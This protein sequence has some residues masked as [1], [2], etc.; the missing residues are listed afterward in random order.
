[1]ID[2][3]PI[4]AITAEQAQTNFVKKT[5]H[6]FAVQEKFL[7]K[8]LRTYQNTELGRKYGL[9]DIKNIEQFQKQVPVLPYS[10]YEPYVQRVA[11]GE[12]NILTSDKVVYL[13]RTSGSTGKQK[14]IPVTQRFQNIM[15]WANLISIGFLSQGLRGQGK[16][17]GKLI[18]TYAA[19]TPELTSGGIEYG[20]AGTGVLRM[21]SFLYK[22]L[23][24]HPFSTLK[25]K[26]TLSRSYVCLLFALLHPPMGFGSNFPMVILQ[27]CNLLEQYA[28]DLI[29]DLE[30][31]TIAPWLQLEPEIRTSLEAQLSP[32]PWRAHQLRE[33]LNSVGKLTPI[34]AWPNLAFYATS[35]GGTSD[36]YL[37][38]FP[39]YFGDTPGFG[40]IFSTAEGTFSIYPDLNTDGSILAIDTGFFEFI[41]S[42]QWEE[43][44]P[45]TVLAQEVKPGEYYRILVTNHSGFYRYD[46][47][48]IFEVV[49]FY[50]QAPLLV[51]RHRRGGLLSSTTEKT[52]EYHATKVMQILQQKFAVLLEDFCI[53]LSD[54]EFPARYLVNI[55]LAGDYHLKDEDAYA[56]IESFDSILKK[57]HTNYDIQRKI[58]VPPPS[59]R[60]M[61]TGSFNIIRQRQIEKGIPVYQLKFPHISEDRNFMAG[62]EFEEEVQ[63]K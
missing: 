20:S 61:K 2:L 9:K 59:L 23:F 51:F 25:S 37:E 35:R 11:A 30:T 54:N 15:G 22:Q 21:G 43:E 4:L 52:T 5:R 40:V 1:M 3:L 44:H 10:A 14:L 7:F 6:T 33:I 45:K 56:F 57:I 38:R 27:I 12:K 55:E 17:F 36:F 32:A 18:T 16:K 50:E 58:S 48:D 24:A 26:D 53:T 31:G 29:N 60:I 47:G 8:L 62:L 39:E 63:L 28:E 41:P 34:L 19:A 42:E 13:N 46:I 49:G